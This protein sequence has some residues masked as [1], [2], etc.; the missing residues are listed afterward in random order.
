MK[1]GTKS[2]L[3]T[4]A[5]VLFV[6]ALATVW[7]SA[8]AD[9]PQVPAASDGPQPILVPA[10]VELHAV[11]VGDA[12]NL[13][14]T[15]RVTARYD[16]SLRAQLQGQS[17]WIFFPDSAGTSPGVTSDS[18]WWESSDGSTAQDP[19]PDEFETSEDWTEV[20]S[21]T[22]EVEY[23]SPRDRRVYP[24]DRI[25][26]LRLQAIGGQ[27]DVRFA[28]VPEIQ[29][30]PPLGWRFGEPRF[31]PSI[32]GEAPASS[33]LLIPL[34]RVAWTPM[35]RELVP[36]VAVLAL[37]FALI[38]AG[39]GKGAQRPGAGAAIACGAALLLIVVVSHAVLRLQL[40]SAPIVY[41]ESFHAIAYLAILAVVL[42]GVTG[43][44]VLSELHVLYWPLISA[45]ALLAAMALLTGWQ[46]PASSAL[47]PLIV[48]GVL[49]LLA[50]LFLGPGKRGQTAP[51]TDTPLG[52]L[53]HLT[54]T[55]GTRCGADSDYATRDPQQ[56]TCRTCNKLL[57]E[58]T[59][60]P[61]PLDTWME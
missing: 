8:M 33:N 57:Y 38:L 43:G 32:E 20:W 21:W 28:E 51:G 56:V 24:F 41:I 11:Q 30:T 61:R 1:N 46:V 48:A 58:G 5:S 13:R 42:G 37:L 54:P 10:S 6:A 26:A 31:E 59:D 18:Q 27:L 9:R 2:F 47:I 45:T 36:L 25:D 16:A 40:G 50:L 52:V 12:G 49:C 19:S 60:D 23:P 29:A 39:S 15:G 17:R 35:L 44:K 7:L 53:H 34:Q 55:G 3:S 22:F 4:L 14:A